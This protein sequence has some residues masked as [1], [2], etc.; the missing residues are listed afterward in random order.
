MLLR[1]VA[2]GLLCCVAGTTA[3]AQAKP[4]FSKNEAGGSAPTAEQT[5]INTLITNINTLNTTYNTYKVAYD[6]TKRCAMMGMM[7]VPH[8][9]NTAP[10]RVST[11]GCAPFPNQPLVREVKATTNTTTGA[12]GASAANIWTTINAFVNSNGCLNSEG[13][14]ACSDEQIRYAF[15]KGIPL[16]SDNQIWVN[17]IDRKF[18][19]QTATGATVGSDVTCSENSGALRHWSNNTASRFG[20]ILQNYEGTT[21]YGITAVTCNNTL[22][23]ACCR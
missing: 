14:Y 21:G 8:A 4:V 19:L 15:A 1:W 23:V 22:K 20:A 3:W 11:I 17:T 18:P 7:Y 2:I 5:R 16:P 6:K 10:G 12:M 13:W 9:S